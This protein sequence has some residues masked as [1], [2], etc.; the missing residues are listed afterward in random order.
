MNVQLINAEVISTLINESIAW[1]HV[2]SPL[3]HHKDNAK[4]TQP[5]KAYDIGVCSMDSWS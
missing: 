5:T 2:Y 3:I 4:A 1:I